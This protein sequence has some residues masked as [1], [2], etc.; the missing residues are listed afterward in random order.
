MKHLR[1]IIM[2]LCV[3]AC[4]A[5][6]LTACSQKPQEAAADSQSILVSP[7]AQQ[8]SDTHESPAPE[9]V[10]IPEQAAT[11]AQDTDIDVDLTAMSSTMVYSQVYDMLT[12]PDNYVGK[13][14]KVRGQY[15]AAY[16][17]ET[18]QYYHFVVI[19]DATACCQQGMEFLWLGEHNYPGDYP[20]DNEVIEIT[21]V[22]ELYEEQ[23]NSYCRLDVPDGTDL[24]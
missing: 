10:F 20:K 7:A 24:S 8:S 15:Y 9:Q 1:Y 14:V 21:G 5:T 13:T 22:F 2:Q 3:L 17:E 4:M 16:S 19:A 18:K 6:L 12:F 23:G 11:P